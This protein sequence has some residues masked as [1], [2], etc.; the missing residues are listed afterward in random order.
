MHNE[1]D[2]ATRSCVWA[3]HNGTKGVHL[4]NWDTLDKAE[5]VGGA[6]LKVAKSM[7][8]AL[9]AKLAWRMWSSEGELWSQVLKAKYGVVA[10]DGAH[11]RSKERSSRVWKAIGSC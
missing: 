4:I 9:L 5:E 6:S 3:K 1:L 7:N 10:A 11:L 8:W 2:R